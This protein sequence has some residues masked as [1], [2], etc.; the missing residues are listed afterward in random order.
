MNKSK[1]LFIAVIVLIMINITTLYFFISK[2][3]KSKHIEP[4]ELIAKRLHFNEKQ[5]I[6]YDELIKFHRSSI[7]DMDKSINETKTI[8]FQTLTQTESKKILDSLLQ[9]IAQKQLK[10]EQIHYN[11]LLDIK[12]ICTENQLQDYNNLT[13]EFLNIF[14]KLPKHNGHKKN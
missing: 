10:I 6:Q 1:L 7:K 5:I 13:D 8:L 3:K 12:K 2:G 9:E 4:K 14:S 11:H